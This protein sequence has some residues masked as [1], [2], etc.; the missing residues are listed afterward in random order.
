ML[1]IYYNTD[2][3]FQPTQNYLPLA[4]RESSLILFS[5]RF[6]IFSLKRLREPPKVGEKRMLEDMVRTARE[7]GFDDGLTGIDDRLLLREVL[8]YTN[9]LYNTQMDIWEGVSYCP[10]RTL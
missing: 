7:N 6:T 2:L 9:Q 10:T 1:F 5:F 4:W 3:R 8:P